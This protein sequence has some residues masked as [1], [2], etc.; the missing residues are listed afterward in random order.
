MPATPISVNSITDD[1]GANFSENVSWN[2]VKWAWR[3][4]FNDVMGYSDNL[5][6]GG[7]RTNLQSP[8]FYPLAVARIPRR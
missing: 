8:H 2:P 7:L 5:L 3:Y 4:T 6:T 1:A